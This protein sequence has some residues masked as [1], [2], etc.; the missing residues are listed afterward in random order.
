MPTLMTQE[1]VFMTT[2][3]VKTILVINNLLLQCQTNLIEMED[4]LSRPN[5]LNGRYFVIT[6]PSIYVL[7]NCTLSVVETNII[8]LGNATRLT[9][10]KKTPF[11]F[12]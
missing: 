11:D 8:S 10:K 1:I 7:I 12:W 4:R 5:S 2:S 3:S 6:R 9:F